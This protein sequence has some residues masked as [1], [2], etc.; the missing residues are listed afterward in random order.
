LTINFF[1]LL[2]LPLYSYAQSYVRTLPYEFPL[3][4]GM[5]EWK[6]LSGG[7]EM[8][9]VTTV[10]IEILDSLSA[11]ALVETCLNHPLLFEIMLHDNLLIGF[12]RLVPHVNCLTTLLER[13]DVSEALILQY[14]GL[15]LSRQ[16]HDGRDFRDLY[17]EVILSHDSIMNRMTSEELVRLRNE[18]FSKIMDKLSINDVF[19]RFSINS[20]ALI[21]VKCLFREGKKDQLLVTVDQEELDLFINTGKYCSDELL[22][23]IINLSK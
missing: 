6:E 19:G 22:Q 4:P 7:E 8:A 17:L 20:S 9:K 23:Q 14:E 21:M 10:P 12:E 3:R 11:D 18:A 16:V 15:D 13:Q 2:I 1:L 5:E